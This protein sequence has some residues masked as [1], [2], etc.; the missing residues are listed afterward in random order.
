MGSAKA[1]YE[2]LRSSRSGMAEMSMVAQRYQVR[3][4][5]VGL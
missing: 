4:W 3:V 2:L 5:C 1:R